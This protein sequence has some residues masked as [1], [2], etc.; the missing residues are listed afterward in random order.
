MQDGINKIKDARGR[1]S[2]KGVLHQSLVLFRIIQFYIFSGRRSKSCG[3][4]LQCSH[5]VFHTCV[6]MML[7][8]RRYTKTRKRQRKGVQFISTFSSVG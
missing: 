2:Q 1:G 8:A 5:K 7:C 3:R 4:S 6:R